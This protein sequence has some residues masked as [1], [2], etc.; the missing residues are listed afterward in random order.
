MKPTTLLSTVLVGLILAYGCSSS[1]DN[2]EK[3]EKINNDKI[4]KQ[5]IAVSNDAKE[6]AK[7]VS[8]N[9]VELANSS[10]TEFELS[11]VALKKATNPEV[12]AYAQ[13]VMNDHQQDDK[14]LQSLAKQMN[15]TLPTGLSDK[16]NGHLGKLTGMKAGTEFDL[17]YLENMISVNDDALDA[18]DDLRDHAPND[19]AKTFARKLLDDDEKHKKQAKQLKNVLD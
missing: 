11:K 4:D 1:S 10:L 3:A 16:S 7:G 17:Q 8:K 19:A 14:S 18:A 2:T 9:M 6:E 12:K 5:A 15:V 13:R